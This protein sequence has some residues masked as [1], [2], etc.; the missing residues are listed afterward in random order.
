ML[1]IT[2][3]A[4]S[5]TS[6]GS[7]TGCS[8][9]DNGRDYYTAGYVDYQ[10][11][12]FNDICLDNTFVLEASCVN[13][14]YVKAFIPALTAYKCPYGCN[15]R[16]C[17]QPN[18]TCTDSDGLNYFVKGTAKEFLNGIL[19]KQGTD[20]CIFNATTVKE[21]FCSSNR[22]STTIYSCSN[23]CL[24]G[25]CKNQICIAN[26]T[27]SNGYQKNCGDD[28]CGG[29]CGSCLGPQL[30]VSGFCQNST[31]NSS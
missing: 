1:A 26:C 20:F 12:A 11:N 3:Y 22:L 8:D 28:G 6:A 13:S 5:A 7:S 24:N 23:G 2:I 25:A 4:L 27:A 14:S 16:A 9:T 19:K 18:Y 17:I 21:Y 29:S 10:G 31:M 15:N 30:C